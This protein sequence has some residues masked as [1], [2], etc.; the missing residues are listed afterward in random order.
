MRKII[1]LLL[2]A[3]FGTLYTNAQD[4]TIK[5]RIIDTTENKP[6][7][8]AVVTILKNDSSLISFARTDKTGSFNVQ[9]KKPGKYVYLVSYPKFADLKDNIEVNNKDL[10][11]GKLALT[12]KSVL[13]EEVIVRTGSAIR[14]KGDTTEFTA[15]SFV[16]KEGAT[17]EDLMKKLPGFQV[18]SKGEI[19]AQGKRV[20]K[21]LVDGEEFFGDDPTMATQNLSAKIVDKVQVYDTKTEQQQLTGITSGNEGKTVNIKL[22]EDKKTGAFGKAH[23]AYDFDNYVDAKALYNRFVGKKKLSLYGTKSNI[24]TGSLNWED[25]QKLGMENDME[26][27]EIGGYYY[28]FNTDDG[29]SDWSLRGL[30]DSYSAG[31]M[32]SNKW[33]EDKNNLNLSYR[34]NRLGTDNLQ[35]N[36]ILFTGTNA[37]KYRNTDT[38]S[39][40]LNQQHAFNGKY[41][42]KVDSLTSFKLSVNG[43]RKVTDLFSNSSSASL[44]SMMAFKNTS[45]QNKEN[46]TTRLQA[47]N[48]LVYRQMFNK[49]NRLMITTLRF[50]IT[51]DDQEG[52]LYSFMDFYKDNAVDSNSTVDQLKNFKGTSETIGGKITFSE[53]LNEKLNLVL[54]YAHNR[55]NSTS[56]RNS[57]N[58]GNNG[59]YEVLDSAFSNNFDMNAY[60]NSSMAIFRFI[61][62]KVRFAAGSGI[63]SVKLNLNDLNSEIK[64][65]YNFL[66]LTPQAQVSYTFKP[67]TSI[68]INYRGTTRQPTINQ[69]QP[70][71]D[72]ND[73]LFEFIGNPDLKVGFNH[74]ISSHFNQYK[75]LSRRGIWMSASYNI[76]NNAIV[77][78]TRFD[79]VNGKITYSPVNTSGVRSWN[80]WSN[81]NKGGGPKQ[82]G[83]GI[84][85][86]GNG[87]RNINFVDYE[88]NITDYISTRLGFNLFYDNP[89]KA[90]IEF[91]PNLAYSSSKSDGKRPVDLSYFSYG[92]GM[93]GFLML[94]GK[95]ELRSDINFDLRQRTDEFPGDTDI[96][97]WNASIARKIGK[98]GKLFITSND[99]LN[100]NTGFN[101]MINSNQ[102]T[103]DRYSRISRYF[104]LKFEWSFTQ[105]PGTN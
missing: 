99:L 91:R 56:Y 35:S 102:I 13:L 20:D 60:S 104:F 62:K 42:W 15:D 31:A 87:G 94:P 55:N 77:N 100:Q 10:D 17:V 105:M 95:I 40:G 76:S 22:K 8:F 67:Q 79:P 72:N 4:F 63:S 5:G 52:N 14:I 16:V 44:D 98:N 21:V 59:K 43:L 57:F 33:K 73:P 80:V 39:N 41:E 24:N 92:G 101:R 2:L 50:G 11:L 28:S 90:S 53:P 18:N 88:K 37:I 48:Q 75:V 93:S 47:D 23:A 49:K 29:F 51:E 69:L 74:S 26:F 19:I 97:L 84:N 6:I 1:C 9:V 68:S 70:L 38:R 71:R 25:R 64:N 81:W 45:L 36:N 83:Y 27:D 66:N 82:L 78:S 32:Y 103:E 86:S 3:C 7:Q 46:H 61:D 12:P 96:I 54:E 85:L 34:F 65:S 58:K 30:P 89:D